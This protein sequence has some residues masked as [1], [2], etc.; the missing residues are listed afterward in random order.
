MYNKLLSC[1]CVVLSD[2]LKSMSQSQCVIW[3][4]SWLIGGGERSPLHVAMLLNVGIAKVISLVTKYSDL[5][6]WIILV[7][8]PSCMS[9]L[10]V[11][12]QLRQ[13]ALYPQTSVIGSQMATFNAYYWSSSYKQLIK[14]LFGRICS[15]IR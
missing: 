7:H 13:M 10:P 9:F 1:I 11:S 12:V 3:R 5:Y 6:F 8:S 4:T 15:A 2:L 14:Q